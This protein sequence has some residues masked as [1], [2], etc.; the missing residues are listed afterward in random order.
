VIK[1][2]TH[3]KGE[4][5]LLELPPYRKPAVKNVVIKSW[6]RMREFVYIVIPFLIIGGIV[7]GILD[8]LGLTNAVVEPF[9][10]ITAWLGL[11]SV[12]IIPL[13]FGFLQKDLT[14]A[15]LLSVIGTEV[16]SVLT[17]IQIYT[18]G[19][20]ATIGIPCIIALGMII[21]E[22]GFRKAIL[23]T[24]SSIFYGVLLAGLIW[25]AIS[26]L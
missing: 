9:S 6:I 14:G 16:S 7:Y 26:I 22:F 8:T 3:A 21:R 5:L 2:V 1:K 23:L 18:F 12:A 25:R 13:I 17:P 24:V 4:P 19:V 11:P 10:P 15:M 20:A